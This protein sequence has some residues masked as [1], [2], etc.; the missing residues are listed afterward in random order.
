M[1]NAFVN[2]LKRSYGEDSIK[3]LQVKGRDD[4]KT[5]IFKSSFNLN[6]SNEYKNV[7]TLV[8]CIKP[9]QR[10]MI[11]E[12]MNDFPACKTIISFM[13]G[14]STQVMYE[15]CGNNVHICRVMANLSI[16]VRPST[17]AAYNFDA[18]NLD[19]KEVLKA[20]GSC[21]LI[22]DE[23]KMHAITVLLGSLPA[24]LLEF[25]DQIQSWGNQYLDP[26]IA[27]SLVKESSIAACEMVRSD[28]SIQKTILDIASKGGVTEAGL[29]VMR[30]DEQMNLLQSFLNT[31]LERSREL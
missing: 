18:L 8:I 12:I 16:G 3:S 23:D 9:H 15:I 31:A 11:R 5:Q 13:A 6:P 25:T 26:T 14:I 19:C 17:I 30:S 10:N 1:A 29:N 27:S 24:F 2:G 28:V 4:Q 21:L 20:L 22:D 7:K